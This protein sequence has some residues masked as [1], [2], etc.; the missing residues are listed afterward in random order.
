MPRLPAKIKL[1]GN[2]FEIEWNAMVDY[3][4]SITPPALAKVTAEEKAD[5]ARGQTTY[6]PVCLDD[7]RK[8]YIPIK[9][10]GAIYEQATGEGYQAPDIETE[11]VPDD[12]TILQ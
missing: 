9:I 3:L 6:V 8:V 2:P 4:R 7:G 11:A 12:A 5:A 1:G 10:Y